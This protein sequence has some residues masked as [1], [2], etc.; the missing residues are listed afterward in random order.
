L[1]RRAGSGE[2]GAGSLERGAWSGERGAGSLELGAGSL[3][4]GAGSGELG[5]TSVLVVSETF[6]EGGD[7]STHF[8]QL[9]E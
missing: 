1:E 2:L 7:H 6:H 5:G 9:L 8:V 3:E 4:R